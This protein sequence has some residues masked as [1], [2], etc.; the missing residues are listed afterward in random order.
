MKCVVVQLNG[1]WLTMVHICWVR[2]WM[3]LCVLCI[4]DPVNNVLDANTAFV[5][6]R[7][8]NFLPSHHHMIV[9]QYNKFWDS[10]DL[11]FN[12]S[13]AILNATLVSEKNVV[14]PLLI[15]RVFFRSYSYVLIKGGYVYYF[16]TFFFFLVIFFSFWLCRK[17]IKLSGIQWGLCLFKELRLLFL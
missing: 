6:S 12:D 2:L 3:S 5:R 14:L 9:R 1:L 17:T 15:F 4:V 8:L 13:I 10:T 7:P 16:L 11:S